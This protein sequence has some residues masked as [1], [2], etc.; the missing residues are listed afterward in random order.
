MNMALKYLLQFACSAI[1]KAGLLLPGLLLCGLFFVAPIQA[2]VKITK[3][4]PLPGGTISNSYSTT[5]TAT[6]CGA[7]CVWTLVS[8]SGTVPKGL[9]LSTSGVLSGTPTVA[10]TSNFTVRATKTMASDQMDFALTIAPALSITTATLA[11]ATANAAYSRTL[12]QTGGLPLI[13]GRFLQVLS[14]QV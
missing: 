10:G 8:G 3:T 11:G 9:S 1:S 13:R 5:F 12:A 6:G 2:Q 14:Q 4:S 7:S